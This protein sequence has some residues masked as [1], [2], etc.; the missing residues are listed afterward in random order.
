VDRKLPKQYGAKFA[1]GA[2]PACCAIHRLGAQPDFRALKSILYKAA[3]DAIFV[4]TSP[5]FICELAQLKTSGVTQ[6]NIRNQTVIIQL[7]P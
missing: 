1:I 3:K 5:N 7:L 4:T 6:R 2:N